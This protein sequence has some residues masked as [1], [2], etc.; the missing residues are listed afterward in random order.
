MKRTWVVL[1]AAFLFAGC[2]GE[3]KDDTSSADL[4]KS[5]KTT[6]RLQITESVEPLNDQATEFGKQLQSLSAKAD[7]Q[8]MSFEFAEA[9]TTWK[10]VEE[11]LNDKFGFDSW[12]A[13]NARQA[14]LTAQA[15]AQFTPE[16]VEQLRSIFQKQSSIGQ[17]LRNS[18]IKTAMALSVES[19]EVTQA[20]FGANS[21]MMGKQLMQLG[22]MYQ[23]VGQYDPAAKQFQRANAILEPFLGALHP[24]LE[25]G[26]AYLGE[27]FLAQN[28]TQDAIV[29]HNKATDIS[30]QLWGESSLRFAARANDLGAAYHRNQEHD[31]AIRILRIAEEIRRT[32]L[33]AS[34]PQVAHSLSNLGV[35]YLDMGKT[36]LA[37]TH[38]DQSHEVFRQHYGD[39]HGLTAECKSKLATVKML[40]QKPNEA[41]VLLTQLI[42]LVQDHSNPVAIA[43]LQYRLAIAL[44]R[45]GKYTRA[46]PLFQSALE[47]QKSSFGENHEVTVNTMKAYAMLLKQSNRESEARNMYGEIDRVAQ[48]PSSSTFR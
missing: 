27:V 1:F 4:M 43:T 41:E 11:M 16:Q 3:K 14:G 29:Y 5:E 34:H 9:A 13:I 22:R 48:Q 10:Q 45:Q 7:Q 36:D 47:L 39:S 44:S 35:V 24:E 12:Q 21:F 25:I 33:S 37:E 18:D 6:P 38:L 30:R 17:A 19:S 32:R 46:E 40:V 31:A 15:E 20:L 42:N 2:G 8:Q 28:K 23:Q 26:N